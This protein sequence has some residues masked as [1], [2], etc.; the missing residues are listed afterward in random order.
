MPYDDIPLT[1]PDRDPRLSS[2]TTEITTWIPTPTAA[3]WRS[4]PDVVDVEC[5]PAPVDD[6]EEGFELKL[7]LRPALA[8][9]PS[10]QWER[11]AMPS[12][13]PEFEIFMEGPPHPTF[14]DRAPDLEYAQLFVEYGDDVHPNGWWVARLW[15]SEA[16]R[17]FVV[18]AL[19]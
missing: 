6:G 2:A 3:Y 18:A 19:S 17:R 1:H 9:A 14:A 15:L 10:R 12:R 5:V 13:L 16:G 8:D 7:R 11:S 4:H